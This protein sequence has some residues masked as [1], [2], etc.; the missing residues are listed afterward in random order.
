M[1]LPHFHRKAPRQQRDNKRGL[2]GEDCPVESGHTFIPDSRL[3]TS[4]AAES[5]LTRNTTTDDDSDPVDWS[6]I[7]PVKNLLYKNAFPGNGANCRFEP[8][9]CSK[10]TSVCISQAGLFA[11]LHVCVGARVVDTASNAG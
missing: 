9:R 10:S 5:S 2:A 1:R 4:D 7:F 6:E 8:K 3:P 11:D